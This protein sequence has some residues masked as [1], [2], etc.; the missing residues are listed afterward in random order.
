MTAGSYS[1]F[2]DAVNTAEMPA[3]DDIPK[4]KTDFDFWYENYQDISDYW[5]SV[6]P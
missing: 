2:P 6:Q 4:F 3:Y 1:V 5:I